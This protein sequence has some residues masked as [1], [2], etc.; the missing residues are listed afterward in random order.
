MKGGGEGR[1]EMEFILITTTY[2]YVGSYR[3]QE[4]FRK[5]SRR[6]NKMKDGTSRYG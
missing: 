2:L 5:G 6:Y 1:V 3:K 4:Y